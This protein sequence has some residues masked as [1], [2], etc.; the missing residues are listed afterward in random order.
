MKRA[1]T[2]FTAEGESHD[3]E[4]SSLETALRKSGLPARSIVA[5][6]ETD[7]LVTPT[8]GRLTVLVVRQRKAMAV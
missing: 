1:Y 6:I 2:V 3:V 4:A 5:A 8:P 7:S